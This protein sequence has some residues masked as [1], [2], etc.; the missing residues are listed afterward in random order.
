MNII[1]GKGLAFARKTYKKVFT[2]VN[3]V[4]QFDLVGPDAAQF[5]KKRLMEKDPLMV[6]RFGWVELNS[7][8]AYV[9][10]KRSFIKNSTDFITGKT[11]FFWHDKIAELMS[12][13]AGFFPPTEQMVDRFCELMLEDMKCVDILGSWRNEE[14]LFKNELAHAIKVPLA[15]LDPYK[16]EEPWSEA[17]KGKTVLLIHPFETSIKAQYKKREYLFKDQRILP[18]FELKTIKAVQSIANN[19]TGFPDWFA[20][21]DHMKNRISDTSFDIAIIGCGA[22][23]FPLAAH[24]KRLGKKA[25]HLGGATQILFGIRGKRWDTVKYVSCHY[26]Q[27]WISPLNEEIPKDFTKVEDGCYW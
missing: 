2:P 22:Y 11:D 19:K 21:L 20:A 8:V 27:H 17:L 26:N 24:V 9:N 10:R 14:Y 5:I 25:V 15:D 1:V 12:T 23:G 6:C 16:N 3:R 13:N 4:D 18:E 7:V